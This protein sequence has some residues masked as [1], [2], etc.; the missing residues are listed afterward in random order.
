MSTT[1]DSV[2]GPLASVTIGSGQSLLAAVASIWRRKLLVLGIVATALALGI[3]AVG[4]MP[5]RYK[6][7]AYIRGEYFAA[8]DTVAKDA[9]STTAG[10]LSLDL[11]RVLETQSR[12]LESR[13]LARR[14]VQQLG[15]ERLKLLVSKRPLWPATFFGSSVK[16]PRDEID[17]A[18]ARL[19]DG[20]SVTSDPR[21]YLLTVRYSAGEPELAELVT[22]AFVAELLRSAKLQTLFKQRSLAQATLSIQLAKFGEKHPSVAQ[23][24][25]RLAATEA[26]LKEQLNE[27]P[28][29]ILQA[30][31]E[32]VT[33]AVSAPSSFTY[34][35]VLLLLAGL[36]IGVGVALWLERGRWW[37]ILDPSLKP[38]PSR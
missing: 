5:A 36:A 3:I 15:L 22:N 8:P 16:A 37:V 20:L 6:A 23:A 14:V 30:A 24:R 1:L 11:V 32:N 29:T 25:M 13:L 38:I 33:R 31:G 18:A 28:E 26:L 12:L 19:L 35:I 4:A 21:A 2:D 17:A 27:D 9:E 34:V 10:S 7:Q